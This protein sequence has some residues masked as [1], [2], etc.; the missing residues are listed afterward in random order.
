MTKNALIK[1]KDSKNNESAIFAK[2]TVRS[3]N[4]AFYIEYETIN[5][6]YIIGISGDIITVSR[7]A[8]ESYTMV[9]QENKP[10]SFDIETKFGSIALSMLPLEVTFISNDKGLEIFLRYEMKTSAGGVEETK[11]FSLSVECKY[12]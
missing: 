12:N 5:E 1:I 3:E 10:H 11:A 6:K 7:I 8:D 9:L 2:G 4:D